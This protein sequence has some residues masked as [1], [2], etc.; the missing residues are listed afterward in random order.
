MNSSEGSDLQ[1]HYKCVGVKAVAAAATYCDSGRRKGE[2][3]LAKFTGM[4][5]RFMTEGSD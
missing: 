1:T 2:S 3:T 5:S 4:D